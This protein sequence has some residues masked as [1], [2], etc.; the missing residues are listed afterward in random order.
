MLGGVG[1][2]QEEGGAALATE[3]G[4]RRG[5]T[6]DLGLSCDIIIQT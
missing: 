3:G 5:E 6:G 2:Q 4:Q 1:Q